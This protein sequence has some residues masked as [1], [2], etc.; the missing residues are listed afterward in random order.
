ME[1]QLLAHALLLK[2]REVAGELLAHGLVGAP[3]HAVGQH[4]C[5]LRKP[6]P[7]GG[8]KGE[9]RLTGD[10]ARRRRRELKGDLVAA[11]DAGQRLGRVVLPVAAV[12]HAE[13]RA[14][15]NRRRGGCHGERHG[16]RDE[17]RS[18]LLHLRSDGRT[19]DLCAGLFRLAAAGRAEQPTSR[20]QAGDG[21]IR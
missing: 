4:N 18:R 10:A 19:H 17:G 14:V 5:T 20:Q 2:Q 1:P 6:A 16:R 12:A 8:G 21:A 13:L 3:L 11:I 7:S 9:R 15:D